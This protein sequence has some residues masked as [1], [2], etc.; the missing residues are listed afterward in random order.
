[1]VILHL[2][3]GRPHRSST[4]NPLPM[5]STTGL[6]SLDCPLTLYRLRIFRILVVFYPELHHWQDHTEWDIINPRLSVQKPGHGLE[7]MTGLES[8]Q[9]PSMSP[10]LS[11]CKHHAGSEVVPTSPASGFS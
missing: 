7:S 9:W 11:S 4:C 3:F 1:M 10:I 8:G 2:I 6:I 5:W